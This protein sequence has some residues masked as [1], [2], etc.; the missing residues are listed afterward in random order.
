MEK[1]QTLFNL[2][3]VLEVS[4]KEYDEWCRPWKQELIVK[5][6]EKSLNLQTMERWI[7]PRWTKKEANEVK[8]VAI[9]IKILNLPVELYNRY[10]LWKVEKSIGTMLK[11]DEHTSI[12]SRDKFACI[13]V[14][15]DLKKKLVSSFS[16][17]EKEFRL[18]YDGPHLICFNYGRYGY[19][20]YG[21]PKKMKEVN[22]R[23]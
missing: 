17:L 1:S 12:Y 19:K 7:N 5:P 4:L 14:K 21:C 9:W 22:D 3:L 18:E 15:I 23:Q 13:F 6:L 8:K 11:V 2:N 16:A 20:Y 10:F